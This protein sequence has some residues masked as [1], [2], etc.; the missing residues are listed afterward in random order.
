MNINFRG[1]LKYWEGVIWGNKEIFYCSRKEEIDVCDNIEV[2]K[3][4]YGV[5]F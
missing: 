5:E 2:R 1:I 4:I 3:F